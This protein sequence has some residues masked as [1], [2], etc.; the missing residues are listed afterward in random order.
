M[1]FFAWFCGLL[2]QLIN[3]LERAVAALVRA[4]F[5][6]IQAVCYSVIVGGF[7]AAFVLAVILYAIFYAGAI[8]TET[9]R[10]ILTPKRSKKTSKIFSVK[11][12]PA[13]TP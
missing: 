3:W 12:S 7:I 5:Y 11:R 13:N 6:S 2:E 8:I 9:L 10:E 4:F 1:G